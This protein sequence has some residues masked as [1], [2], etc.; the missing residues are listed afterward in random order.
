MLDLIIGVT[1]IITGHK[2]ERMT[3]P[4]RFRPSPFVKGFSPAEQRFLQ[5]AIGELLSDSRRAGSPG[6][7]LCGDLVEMGER[8]QNQLGVSTPV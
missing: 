7:Q 4:T 2:S 3:I 8:S 5:L 6:S 1:D